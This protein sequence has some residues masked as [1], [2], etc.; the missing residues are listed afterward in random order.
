MARIAAGMGLGS[1]N[2]PSDAAAGPVYACALSALV[3]GIAALLIAHTALFLSWELT[4]DDAWISFRSARSLV[5]CVLC[6]SRAASRVARR[7]CTRKPLVRLRTTREPK[8]SHTLCAAAWDV[9]SAALVTTHSCQKRSLSSSSR[10]SLFI[11]IG[12]YLK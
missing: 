12:S 4:V 11:F 6:V 8:D 5:A 1:S 7:F 9:L 3:L 10:L 2:A